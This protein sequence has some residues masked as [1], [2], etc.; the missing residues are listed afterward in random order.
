MAGEIQIMIP[1]YGVV[2]FI[3]C[4]IFYIIKNLSFESPIRFRLVNYGELAIINQ[5]YRLFSKR[6]WLSACS[7]RVTNPVITKSTSL[8]HSISVRHL[9]VGFLLL[10]FSA[11]LFEPHSNPAVGLLLYLCT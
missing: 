7:D 4:Q 8:A 9:S 2:Y 10:T 1:Q 3:L 5:D 11:I 6:R